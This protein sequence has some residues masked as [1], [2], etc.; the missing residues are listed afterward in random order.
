MPY[1]QLNNLFNRRKKL[2]NI[3][4]PRMCDFEEK[5]KKEKEI[6]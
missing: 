1:L 6:A 2:H 5:E 4:T 3:I